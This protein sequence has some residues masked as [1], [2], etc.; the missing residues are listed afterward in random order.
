MLQ[1]QQ[2]VIAQLFLAPAE[3]K[4]VGVQDQEGQHHRDKGR[5]HIHQLQNSAGV[6]DASLV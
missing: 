1:A 4:V 3:Q 5:H 2:Q 6:A